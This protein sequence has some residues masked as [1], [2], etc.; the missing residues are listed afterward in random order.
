MYMAF[1]NHD[2]VT[3]FPAIQYQSIHNSHPVSKNFKENLSLLLKL[4]KNN[5]CDMHIF[6][7]P[8]VILPGV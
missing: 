8:V 4:F 5:F 7:Y 6:T 1:V 2:K 3:A